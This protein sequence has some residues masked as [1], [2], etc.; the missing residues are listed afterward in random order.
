MT[1]IKPA[2]ADRF[3]ARPDRNR[4][5][6]LLHG[7]DQGLVAE[8]AARFVRT[9]AGD[10]P[11]ARVHFDAD[12]VA[13]EPARLADEANAVPLFGGERV[14][15]VAASGTR[16]LE[17]AVAPVLASPPVDAWVVIVAGDLRK[18]S[19]LRRLCEGDA[20]A[21]AIACY[22]DA[23]RD[24]DRVI[25]EEAGAA[26]LA[27][28]GDARA[29][30]KSLL[31]ADRLVS[32]GE[33]AKL[34]LYAAG[35]GSITVDDVRAVVGDAA[36]FAVD[37]TVDMVALGDAAGFDR[38]F[39]RLIAAGTPGFVIAGAALRHFNFLQVAR[40]ACDTGTPARS[41][42]ERARPPI[43]FQ[44]QPSVARQIALWSPDL[45]ERALAGLDQAM[46]DSRLHGAIADA[47]IGQALHAVAALLAAPGARMR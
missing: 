8:R 42:V 36:A 31:G 32:R 37:E 10:D 6:I 47:V 33:V 44:R 20:G 2:D 29:A 3:L 22:A 46:V 13:R 34:C 38:G 41:L 25:D 16:S 30:L 26:G 5:V 12:E 21:A 17:A 15:T 18:S 4:R 40:A 35:R 45:V 28:A 27:I 39:R 14:I 11:L 1:A 7:A 24:L 43:F 23:G 19:P 9:V